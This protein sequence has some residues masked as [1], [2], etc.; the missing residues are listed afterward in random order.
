MAA[1]PSPDLEHLK[2]AQFALL[3]DAPAA[4]RHLKLAEIVRNTSLDGL[5]TCLTGGTD[6]LRTLPPQIK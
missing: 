2:N 5:A 6:N 3:Q 1:N 4:I